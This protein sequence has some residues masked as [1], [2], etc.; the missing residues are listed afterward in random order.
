LDDWVG[1]VHEGNDSE[2]SAKRAVRFQG[3]SVYNYGD[4]PVPVISILADIG[5]EYEMLKRTKDPDKK[6]LQRPGSS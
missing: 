2:Q 3:V 1:D 4:I 5:Q 6:K